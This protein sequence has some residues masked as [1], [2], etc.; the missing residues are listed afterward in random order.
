[1]TYV[2]MFISVWSNVEAV[3]TTAADNI[4]ESAE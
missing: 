1:M 4:C 3:L 2:V